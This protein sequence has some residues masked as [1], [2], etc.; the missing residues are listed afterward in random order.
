MLLC[1]VAVG[2]ARRPPPFLLLLSVDT[3]RADRL[4]AYGQALD[5]TPHI[6]ALLREATVFE[7]TYAPC[8]YTLPSV[9]ALL[10]GRYPEELGIHRNIS[11][12]GAD[13]VT[14]AEILQLEGWR[15][16]GVVS[17]YVLRRGTGVE[18]GFDLFDDE[19]PQMEANREVPERIASV[20]TDAALATLDRLLDRATGGVFLWVHYQDPHG[21]YLPPA[22]RRERF[23]E[24]E[25]RR[26][27]GGKH[28]AAENRRGVGSLPAYQVVGEEREVAFYRAGYHGEIAYLD[29]EIGRL[30][31]GIEARGLRESAWIV[32]AADHGEALG[33]RDYWF[34]HGEYL[35]DSLVR[36]PLA[37]RIPGRPPARRDDP[38]SLVDL[39][40]TLLGA[41][42]MPPAASAGRDLFAGPS[43]KPGPIY[44][45]A[46]G[47]SPRPRYGLVLDGYK[48]IANIYA[49][50]PV[51]ELYRLGDEAMDRSGQEAARLRDMRTAL[52]A[53]RDRLQ[54]SPAESMQELSPEQKERLRRLGYLVE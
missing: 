1:A 51:E 2:C 33:E 35:D 12:L 30:L 22:G 41:L 49:Q 48:Y 15:T 46:L 32:F 36:V 52:A 40:P 9:S 25:R 37:I 17:N 23:L 39:L 14:L 18:Q 6:D 31:A 44:L 24:A 26:P 10:T 8:S 54:R 34:A 45:A 13:Q 21:P 20:T 38:A 27:D 47:G 29:D 11:R 16:G 3:L 28:L 19:F 43:G 50:G 7:F 53:F 5:L 42:G 4:G